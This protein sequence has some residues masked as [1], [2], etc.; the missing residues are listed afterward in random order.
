MEQFA[1]EPDIV[2]YIPPLQKRRLLKDGPDLA[3]LAD[4]FRER[5]DTLVK[6]VESAR[7]CYE[8]FCEFE[9]RSAKKHL[10]PVIVEPLMAIRE[11]LARLEQWNKEAIS[12]AI[13]AVASSFDINM[14]KLGQPMRVAVTGG[15]V[16]PPIDVTVW[17]IGQERVTQRLDKAIEFINVRASASA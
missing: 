2:E 12:R 4:G 7:Y 17:L 10:R 6:M 14:G 8:E 15:P 11:R 1:R 13:E 9:A 5:A 3:E 16:S